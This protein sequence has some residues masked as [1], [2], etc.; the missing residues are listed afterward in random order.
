[1]A[2]NCYKRGNTWW[3]RAI[4]K[5]QEYRESLDL[6]TARTTRT[7]AEAAA[8]EWLD[9]LKAELRGDAPTRTFDEIAMHFLTERLPEISPR[10]AQRYRV[11]MRA[12][13][14]FFEGVPLGDISAEKLRGFEKARRADGVTASTIRRDMQ[15]LSSA[16]TF[17]CDHFDLDINNPVQRYLRRRAQQG[18][19]REAPPRQRYLSHDEE[20]SLLASIRERHKRNPKLLHMAEAVE[21]AIDTGLR[22]EEQFSMK[23]SAVD[24]SRGRVTVVGKGGRERVVPLLPRAARILAQLPRHLHSPWIWAKPNGDRY[25]DRHDGFKNACKKAGLKD[26][27]WHDLR[28]TCGCRRLQDHGWSTEQVRDLLGHS[29]V[30]TTERHYAFLEIENLEGHGTESGTG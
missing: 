30:I 28:R 23:W 18:A 24:T 17:F 11:S 4:I 15:C 22:L 9:K 26:V 6:P 16:I 8:A 13:V 12:L 7:V 14:P 25:K 10:G 3:A 27:R 1:M 21:F 20:V 5:G 2:K 29:S 19:L